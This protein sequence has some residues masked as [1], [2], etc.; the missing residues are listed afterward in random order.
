[1]FNV[2]F[3]IHE[4]SKVGRIHCSNK[5]LFHWGLG[6]SKYTPMYMETSKFVDKY[7]G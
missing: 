6:I 2:K 1:M 5:L 3:N 7:L 4:I